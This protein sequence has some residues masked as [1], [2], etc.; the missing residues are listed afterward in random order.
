MSC[1]DLIDVTRVR[2]SMDASKKAEN[3]VHLL[4]RT[5]CSVDNVSAGK[6]SCAVW[7]VSP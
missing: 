3:R 1:E 4:T 5:G 2:L 7:S 6:G